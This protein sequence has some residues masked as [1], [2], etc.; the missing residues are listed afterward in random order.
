VDREVQKEKKSAAILAY[1][2]SFEPRYAS[3][4]SAVQKKVVVLRLFLDLVL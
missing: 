3:G 4:W 1:T 2:Q